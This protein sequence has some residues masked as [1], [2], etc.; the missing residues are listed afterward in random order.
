MFLL[1]EPTDIYKGIIIITHNE[2]WYDWTDF[3]KIFYILCHQQF[4][5]IN[6]PRKSYIDY[7]LRPK[8]F[9][10]LSKEIPMVEAN[11]INE[12][13]NPNYDI[14][15][16]NIKFF[17]LL[18]DYNI[19][20]N[21]NNKNNNKLIDIIYNGRCKE[22]KKT[23]DVL[24]FFKKLIISNNNITCLFLILKQKKENYYNKFILMYKDL[25]DNIKKNI[26]LVDTHNININN[27]KIFHGF[28]LDDVSLFYKT[29]KIY[30][31][32]CESEGGS[33]TIQEALCCG[34]IVM[35]KENMEG[36][37]LDN[38]SDDNSILYNNNNFID[39]FTLA[40]KKY[41]NYKCEP[42]HIN[43]ISIKYTLPK[44]I[45]ILYNS[46]DYKNVISYEKF[47]DNIH[48]SDIQLNICGHNLSVDWY[49]KNE[50]TAQIVNITQVNLF[51]NYINKLLKN[52]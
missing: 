43:N 22:L 26:I 3:K 17:K 44:I 19:N 50:L 28:N 14:N 9:C 23:I 34:C 37:G 4:N 35:A 27:N 8:S 20:H 5:I 18:K 16:I 21:L 33:R 24:N 41:Q 29:S 15:D 10:K 46:F 13:F 1:L 51:K 40:Y 38:L 31:H 30:I 45:T 36:G 32:A 42:K 7:Y 6:I 48:K 39:K 25:P 47:Y 12:C 52:Y 11:L 2:L 49:I